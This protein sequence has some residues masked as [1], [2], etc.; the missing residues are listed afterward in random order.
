MVSGN[1]YHIPL[2][3]QK[4]KKGDLPENLLPEN[5]PVSGI[6]PPIYRPEMSLCMALKS[7]IIGRWTDAILKSD[8]EVCVS[9]SAISFTGM[10]IPLP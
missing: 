7:S 8:G 1:K 9:M 4:P 10:S 3:N 6:S 2:Q 5:N